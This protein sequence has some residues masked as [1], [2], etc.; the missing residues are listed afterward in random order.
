MKK[1]ILG[2]F[3]LITSAFDCS[4]M[5]RFGDTTKS[6]PNVSGH[7]ILPPKPSSLPVATT[8]I[9]DEY[10]DHAEDDIEAAA[11][12][13]FLAMGSSVENYE[14]KKIFDNSQCAI[15]EV[16]TAGGRKIFK[17]GKETVLAEISAVSS[18]YRILSQEISTS[19]R[20]L[21]PTHFIVK[22]EKVV[23]P[24]QEVQSFSEQV[25]RDE[26][27]R[28]MRFRRSDGELGK[29]IRLGKSQIILI[30]DKAS[31]ESLEDVL[32]KHMDDTDYLSR[33]FERIGQAIAKFHETHLIHG[34]IN[35]RNVFIDS[36]G[37]VTFID[38]EF[39]TADGDVEVDLAPLSCCIFE[40]LAGDE[41]KLGDVLRCFIS[42]YLGAKRSSAPLSMG[43]LHYL[44]FSRHQTDENFGEKVDTILRE[45]CGDLLV[46]D[47]EPLVDDE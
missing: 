45:K 15:F 33:L 23:S 40:K 37:L 38:F 14:C 3:Y 27:S 43:T 10:K 26:F 30:E 25:F 19:I 39:T 35:P 6:C 7:L 21:F 31:G 36:N 32:K 47:E 11:I 46:N 12:S 44:I 13:Y 29:K 4:A 34:D 41:Q 9:L 16:S 17:K 8:P 22:E 18:N 28:H 24:V 42:S 2:T 5:F 1:I 20:L